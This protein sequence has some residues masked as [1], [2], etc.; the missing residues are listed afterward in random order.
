M[1][2]DI[3]KKLDDLFEEIEGLKKK[4][5]L[6]HVSG[7]KTDFTRDV[8]E[9]KAMHTAIT[10]DFEAYQKAEKQELDTLRNSIVNS[11]N[12]LH[13]KLRMVKRNY[14]DRNK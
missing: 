1:E 12:D 8:E 9:L 3:K 10:Q 5:D 13:H 7:S 2:E 11:H 4:T 6:L 14:E